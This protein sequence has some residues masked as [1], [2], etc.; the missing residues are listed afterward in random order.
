MPEVGLLLPH[1]IDEEIEA[2]SYQVLARG[3][4][5]SKGWSS[6]SN[7]GSLAR[8]HALASTSTRCWNLP[9]PTPV[10]STTHL[11]PCSLGPPAADKLGIAMGDT[12]ASPSRRDEEKETHRDPVMGC[13]RWSLAPQSQ[14]SSVGAHGARGAESMWLMSA[15]G[16]EFQNGEPLLREG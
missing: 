3:H 15:L 4:T 10:L 16:V 9:E 14:V 12:W 11:A 1:L 5:T 13:H 6:D 7:P 2:L 8:A